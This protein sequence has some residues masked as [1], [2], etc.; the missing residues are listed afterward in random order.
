MSE[1]AQR[2]TKKQV[3]RS[4]EKPSVQSAVPQ[5]ELAKLATKP[6][7]VRLRTDELAR[8]EH[9]M[10]VLQIRSTSEALRE[11]LRLLE[12]EAYKEESAAG[13]RAFYQNR[14]APLPD[15][16]VPIDEAEMAASDESEW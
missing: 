5:S 7:Q 12:R 15:G 2:T 13:I 10:R 3:R 14:T 9:S 1:T 11:G 4:T 16:V 6:A 8:L